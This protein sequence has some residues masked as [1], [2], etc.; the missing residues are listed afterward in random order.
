MGICSSCLGG[1]RPSEPEQSDASHLLND[2]YQPNY[3]TANGSHGAPQ[4]DAEE[5]RRQRETL[6]RICAETS[7]QLIPVSQPPTMPPEVAEQ[8]TNDAEYARL[9]DERFATL[10]TQPSRPSSAGAPGAEE[11]DEDEAAWLDQALGGQAEDDVDQIEPTK[12]GL[13]IQFGAR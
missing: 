8:P 10:R 7:E 11:D 6:E 4:P 5:L 1:R 9:F 2:P 12:G 13:T 3:G